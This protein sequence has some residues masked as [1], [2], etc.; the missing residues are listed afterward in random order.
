[1]K[2]NNISVS[3]WVKDHARKRKREELKEGDDGF[4]DCNDQELLPPLAKRRA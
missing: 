3:D 1:M 2:F 4:K